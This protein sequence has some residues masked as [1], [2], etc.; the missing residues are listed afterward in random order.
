[1]LDFITNGDKGFFSNI[2]KCVEI[3]DIK[4]VILGV[5]KLSHVI[6]V[7]TDTVIYI[8]LDLDINESVC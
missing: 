5:V 3:Q 2:T 4:Y 7:W 6:W 1:M 8:I